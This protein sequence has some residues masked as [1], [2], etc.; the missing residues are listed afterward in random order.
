MQSESL[1]STSSDSDGVTDPRRG[2]PGR[3]EAGGGRTRTASEGGASHSAEQ[4]CRSIDSHMS[5][6]RLPRYLRDL[7]HLEHDA[8]AA[9][10]DYAS[11]PGRG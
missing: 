1:S 8:E 5:G 3:R 9:P 11:S 6:L 2:S 10:T 4:N 7:G